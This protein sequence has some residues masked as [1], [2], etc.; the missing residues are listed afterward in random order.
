MQHTHKGTCQVCQARQAVNV[1]TGLLAKHGYQVAGYGFFN[2]TCWGSDHLP[3]EKDKSL[4]EQTIA[5]FTAK[6][7]AI[8]EEAVEERASVSNKVSVHVYVREPHKKWGMTGSYQWVKVEVSV[9][10]V[11]EVDWSGG[12]KRAITEF[13][14]VGKTDAGIDVVIA[15]LSREGSARVDSW[16]SLEQALVTLHDACAKGKEAVAAEMEKYVA[17]Q[18]ARLVGWVVKDLIPVKKVA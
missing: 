9:G 3:F 18:E 1:K 15:D 7:A 11:R 14:G 6:A 8:R 4:V 12:E 17:S 2:G 16:G 13:R 5:H 10:K